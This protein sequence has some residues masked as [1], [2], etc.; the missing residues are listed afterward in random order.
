[1]TVA[2]AIQGSVGFGS[3]LL[4]GPLLILI[5]PQFVPGP[6]LVSS[7]LLTVLVANRERSAIDYA[8]LKYIV[9]G[10]FLGTIPAVFLLALAPRSVFDLIFG[11]M[12]LLAVCLSLFRGSPQITSRALFIAGA[13][14]GLMGTISAIGGPPVALIYQHSKGPRFRATLAMQLLIGG[15]LSL[16]A[17]AAVGYF[18]RTELWLSLVLVPGIICG[19][20][21]SRFAMRSVDARG[22]RPLVL[23]LSCIAGLYVLWRALHA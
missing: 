13:A 10:R 20:S 9:S 6:V 22:V 2:S 4:A 7:L 1:M 3:A 21:I 14:S 16:V 17:I 19:F 18:G 12:V 11:V 15:V 23:M 5:H 8:G